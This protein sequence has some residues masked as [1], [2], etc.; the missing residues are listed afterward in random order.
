MQLS[1]QQAYHAHVVFRY[2]EGE[3]ALDDG[4]EEREGASDILQSLMRGT[5][6]LAGFPPEPTLEQATRCLQTYRFLG[7]GSFNVGICLAIVWMEFCQVRSLYGL[8]RAV[9][10]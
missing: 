10:S 8:R 3:N 6:W 1:C 2:L 7:C 5:F 9:T 4:E